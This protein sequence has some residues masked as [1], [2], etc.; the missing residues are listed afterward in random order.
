MRAANGQF[1]KGTHWRQHQ[2]HWD[3]E[4]LR[5]EYEAKQRSAGDIANEI[6][7]TDA[8]IFYWLKKHGIKRRSVSDA[9][10]LKYWGM[11]GSDNPMFGKVGELNPRYVDGSSPE[12]QL[13][14]ARSEGKEF[15]K[16]IL[17]RD[18]YKCCRCG[19]KHGRG[20]T[21]HVHHVAPWAGNPELRFDPDNT[22]TLCEEC[23]HWVHS[24]SNVDG[25]WLR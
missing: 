12:R 5:T 22:V 1:M 13:L 7:I 15:L 11:S 24:K 20:T 9:R 23:H 3:E 6:G 4:W 18:G 17:W 19:A 16:S 21:L 10:A 8:A 25:E 14:Y 2:P